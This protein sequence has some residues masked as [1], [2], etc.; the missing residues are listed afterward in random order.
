[1]KWYLAKLVYRI[2]CGDGKHTAQ[3]DEQLRLINA[4][5]DLHAF[6]KARLFGEREQDNFLN[7]ADK[8]VHWKFIDVSEIHELNDLNDGVEIYSRI[9]EDDNADIYTKLVLLR[10][11]HLQENLMH[12]SVELN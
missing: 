3:F 2:I 10:A 4:E 1:M 7:A 6:Y 5:D 12:T 11:A 8:P 9:S